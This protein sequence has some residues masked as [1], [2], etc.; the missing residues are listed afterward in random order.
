MV[1]GGA[2]GACTPPVALPAL[3]APPRLIDDVAE[4]TFR[5]FWE[6]TKPA[7][8]LAPDR[9]PSAGFCSIAA[10]GF[11]LTAY[12]IGVERGWISRE[13]AA[14][15]TLATLR[16]FW[17]APQGPAARGVTGYKGFF[18][19][20]IDMEQGLRF[21]VTELSSV[22]TCLLLGG[23]LFA[24]EFFKGTGAE[25]HEI[26]DL[27]NKIYNRV[28]WRWMQAR[29]SLVSM[30]WHPESGFIASDWKGYN[31]AMLVY[32]LGMGAPDPARRL[33]TDAW[34]AWTATYP[35]SWRGQ[36]QGR[37]LAFGPHFGHQY[38]HTWIDFRGIRDAVMRAEGFDYF[39]NSRRATYAQRAY[40]MRNPGGWKGYAADIWGLTACDGPLGG[41]HKVNGKARQFRTYSARGPQGLPDEFDDGT[42]APTA[43]LGS[44]A[45]AP[46]IV[47]PCAE[48]MHAR[49][50][51]RLYE[52]YGFFDSFNPTLAGAGLHVEK[53]IVDPELG[54]FDD[55]YLGIDQGPILAMIANHQRD[56]VWKHMRNSPAIRDGLLRAGFSGGW[57]VR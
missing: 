17:N 56:F 24:A 32:V 35:Q 23:I 54:W 29:G 8:G 47:V 15:R 38:S 45:F 22:D 50:G 43:A 48:A 10:V 26:R 5:F 30:G 2:V 9:W 36:G 11:A 42:L 27:A 51:R 12:P 13:A 7:N 20:F 28:D 40:A 14:Q 44:I 21:G 53:G 25:E 16:F 41:T 39:E 18:Y 57:L 49:Y 55:E 46:E 52:K 1:A 6:T 37:H 34:H 33:G 19:H 31:E 3:G 4:R